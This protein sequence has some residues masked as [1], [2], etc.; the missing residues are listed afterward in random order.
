MCSDV[1]EA[2]VPPTP[3]R[4]KSFCSRPQKIGLVSA[5]NSHRSHVPCNLVSFVA[6]PCSDLHIPSRTATMTKRLFSLSKGHFKGVQH[7][8]PTQAIGSVPIACTQVH[9]FQTWCLQA[10]TAVDGCPTKPY[11]VNFFEPGLPLIC[12]STH[13]RNDVALASG[14]LQPVCLRS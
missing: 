4:F 5:L 1:K 3:C 11:P 14:S 10:L 2:G 8:H 13:S 7:M 12:V 9:V 6:F